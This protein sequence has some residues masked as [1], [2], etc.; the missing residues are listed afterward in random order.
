M[1]KR[2]FYDFVFNRF[3]IIKTIIIIIIRGKL[4][5]IRQNKENNKNAKQK[6]MIVF[7]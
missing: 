1:E 4:R 3:V 6:K 5:I 2:R 7:V